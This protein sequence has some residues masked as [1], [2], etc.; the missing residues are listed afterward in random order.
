[1][2]SGKPARQSQ[3]VI[4]GDGPGSVLP[5]GITTPSDPRPRVSRAFVQFLSVYRLPEVAKTGIAQYP[6]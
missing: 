1:M 6:G 3:S 4:S 5:G 2:K